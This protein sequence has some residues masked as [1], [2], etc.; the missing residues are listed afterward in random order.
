MSGLGAAA[1]VSAMCHELLHQ[2]GTKDLY[3]AGLSRN[4]GSTTM[5]AVPGDPDD[6]VRLDPW[7]ELQ[8]E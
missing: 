2:L 4:A 3:G 6:R 1:G 8:F 7:H 5:A